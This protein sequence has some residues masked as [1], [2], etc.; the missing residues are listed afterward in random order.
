MLEKQMIA[1]LRE[2]VSRKQAQY[3]AHSVRAKILKRQLIE[4]VV[5][6]N[7]MNEDVTPAVSATGMSASDRPTPPPSSLASIKA[8]SA[9]IKQASARLS[10][11]VDE[12]PMPDDLADAAEEILNKA[13]GVSSSSI[14]R[15]GFIT[16]ISPNN[17]TYA[18]LKSMLSSAGGLET[19]LEDT[20]KAREELE[21]MYQ[22]SMSDYA[23]LQSKYE[24]ALNAA[25]QAKEQGMTAQSLIDFIKGPGYA[26]LSPDEQKRVR[27]AFR[28]YVTGET[29]RRRERRAAAR[30]LRV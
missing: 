3:I 8:R 17:N 23:E 28:E 4:S 29:R 19:A 30:T 18:R 25:G 16:D 14:N 6:K 7:L 5:R 22:Q 15:L 20:E 2:A 11:A 9:K 1:L 12:L 10:S 13:S 24:Q 26:Q 27:S 21:G